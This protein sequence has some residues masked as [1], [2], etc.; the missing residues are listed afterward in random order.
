MWSESYPLSK[1]SPVA[2]NLELNVS[3]RAA[4]TFA[5]GATISDVTVVV[6]GSSPDCT[7][8]IV[9]YPGSHRVK[10]ARLV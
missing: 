5:S 3:T 2:S 9:T 6:S 10:L 8:L 7:S 4:A 1:A